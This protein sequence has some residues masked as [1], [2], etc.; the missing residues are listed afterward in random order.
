MTK[1]KI[2]II[3]PEKEARQLYR[4]IKRH[5]REFGDRFCKNHAIKITRKVYDAIKSKKFSEAKPLLIKP[6]RLIH[7]QEKDYLKE[8]AMETRK[9]WREL[10][11]ELI[12]FMKKTMEIPKIEKSTC[13]LMIVVRNGMYNPKAREV[14]LRASNNIKDVCNGIFHEW[15]HVNYVLLKRKPFPERNNFNAWLLSEIIMALVNDE[16]PIKKIW[17]EM[18]GNYNPETIPFIKSMKKLWLKRKNFQNFLETAYP[19]LEKQSQSNGKK[20]PAF[21]NF[22]LDTA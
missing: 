5:S 7:E 11:P 2:M 20:S 21:I 6:I 1:V 22:K 17:P 14:Y 10:E 3:S 8:K 4:L 16:K 18:A 13:K 12:E 9:E 15:F 19:R